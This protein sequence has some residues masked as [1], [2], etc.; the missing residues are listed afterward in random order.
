MNAIGVSK[1][2]VKLEPIS[3]GGLSGFVAFVSHTSVAYCDQVGDNEVAA[4]AEALRRAALALHEEA[5]RCLDRAADLDGNAPASSF[6]QA[7]DV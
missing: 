7:R 2:T 3:I 5:A 6:P 1:P 4:R